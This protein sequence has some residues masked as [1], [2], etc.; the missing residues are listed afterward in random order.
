MLRLVNSTLIWNIKKKRVNKFKNSKATY[1]FIFIP[2]S[3]EKAWNFKRFFYTWNVRVSGLLSL[4]TRAVLFPDLQ[5]FL[6][7]LKMAVLEMP[8]AFVKWPTNTPR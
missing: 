1:S 7:D 5:V 8:V 4:T 2:H 6:K 3:V